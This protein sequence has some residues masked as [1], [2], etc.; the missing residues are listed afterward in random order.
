MPTRFQD[1]EARVSASIDREHGEPTLV[2][3][4][5]ATNGPYLAGGADSS[6]ADL[7]VV[8]IVDLDPQTVRIRD[9]GQYD[10]YRPE[11]DGEVAHV[12]YDVRLFASRA[13]WPANGDEIRAVERVSLPNKFRVVDV[14]ADGIGRILCRCVVAK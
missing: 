9:K 6:R 2:V 12:S 8:G 13:L 14:Q 4:R 7:Q 11:I 5:A 3:R 10:A 1:R